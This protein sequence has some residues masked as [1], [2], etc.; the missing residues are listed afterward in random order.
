MDYQELKAKADEIKEKQNTKANQNY[1][2][3]RKLGFSAREAALLAYKPIEEID[4]IAKDR[5]NGLGAS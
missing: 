3:A 4:R 2:Y 1:H 5:D